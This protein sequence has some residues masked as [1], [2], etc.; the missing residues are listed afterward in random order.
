MSET[1]EPTA[2]EEAAAWAE[3]ESALE[4]EATAWVDAAVQ[5]RTSTPE[6]TDVLKAEPTGVT[7]FTV[8]VRAAVAKAFDESKHPRVKDGPGGKPDGQFA[9][10]GGG[11]EGFL[12]EFEALT[13]E[14]PM[15]YRVR[16]TNFR[17]SSDKRD[18][19]ARVKLYRDGD[20]SIHIEELLAVTRGGGRKAM[21][22]LTEMAD[23]H[24]VILDLYASP[25][26]G[27]RGQHKQR[28][29]KQLM[30]WYREFGFEGFLEP[31]EHRIRSKDSPDMTRTPKGKKQFRKLWDVLKDWVT[32]ERAP[33]GSPIGG[34]WVARMDAPHA[35]P[36]RRR[37][38]ATMRESDRDLVTA[39]PAHAVDGHSKDARFPREPQVVRDFEATW[40]RA[41]AEGGL[42]VAADGTLHSMQGD[43]HHV[44]VP[45]AT[46]NAARN[47]IFTHN[48]PGRTSLPGAFDSPNHRSTSAFSVG[49]MYC[50]LM[51]GTREF[52]AVT[53]H[54]DGLEITRAGRPADI[55]AAVLAAKRKVSA[56][57]QL[58]ESA[59]PAEWPLERDFDGVL[60]S[61]V[62]YAATDLHVRYA[63]ALRNRTGSLHTA[64]AAWAKEYGIPL[65][66]EYHPAPKAPARGRTDRF[67][68]PSNN[69]THRLHQ[70]VRRVVR[71]DGEWEPP[72]WEKVD[73]EWVF[74]LDDRP[75]EVSRNLWD[76]LKDWNPTQPRAP[77]GANNAGQWIT[78]GF[79][80]KYARSAWVQHRRQSAANGGDPL[81][82]HEAKAE[83]A[84]LSAATAVLR[85]RLHLVVTQKREVS[86][87]EENAR[88][89]Y[90]LSGYEYIN[91][92]LRGRTYGRMWDHAI[93][94]EQTQLLTGYV[95]AYRTSAPLRVYRGSK[96]ATD[97]KPG[98]YIRDKA[99]VSTSLSREKARRFGW[100]P[101]DGLFGTLFRI[102]L[103][104]GAVAAPGHRG[105]GEIIVQRNA[106]FRV[107]AV[108]KLKQG[109]VV[110]L[111]YVKIGKAKG[112]RRF[113]KELG[114]D[115]N[116]TPTVSR[117]EWQIGDY[118][119]EAPVEKA[120][121]RWGEETPWAPSGP[122]PGRFKSSDDIIGGGQVGEQGGSNAGG[123]FIG[124][125]GVR[126][127]VKFY[128]NPVQGAAEHLSNAIYRDLGLEA[129]SSELFQHD[130]KL[131]FATE[132]IPNAKRLNQV[133][134]TRARANA[135]LDGFAA[136]I[137][138][139]NW[140]A[141]GMGHDNVVY[142]DGKGRP[143]RA[144]NGGTFQ[145][146]A[147][148]A[149]KTTVIPHE[150]LHDIKEFSSL[151]QRNHYYRAVWDAA[152]VTPDTFGDRMT[153]QVQRIVALRRS[154]RGGWLEYVQH[155]IPGTP[156]PDQELM[157]EMLESR[158]RRLAKRAG[159]PYLTE[160]EATPQRWGSEID[161]A[162]DGPAPG[163]FRGR[164]FSLAP[165][166]AALH[167]AN[168]PG[169]T[170]IERAMWRIE[171]EPLAAMEA[172]RGERFLKYTGRLSVNASQAL[173]AYIG[174]SFEELNDFL[175][176]F[177]EPLSL[178]RTKLE[179]RT[180][181][182]DEATKAWELTETVRVYRM[183]KSI[184]AH[185][186]GEYIHD[187]AFVST[188]M[189]RRAAT[190]F[191]QRW[192]EEA[193]T[194]YRI[195]L[196]PGTT[197]AKGNEFESELIL[198]RNALFRVIRSRDI[199]YHGLPKLSLKGVQPHR[200]KARLV[201][202][203]Y[204]GSGRHP[205]SK[206][207]MGVIGHPVQDPNRF[208]WRD[209]DLTTWREP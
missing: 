127:Y 56:G 118:E 92:L 181:G 54:P 200:Q 184:V 91:N 32:Q 60:F 85:E 150:D 15:N 158:T 53:L 77:K 96:S 18:Y 47:G 19:T 113:V 23:K 20:E 86:I 21:E 196:P 82:D 79:N 98:Q 37:G 58:L 22:F 183:R 8:R 17:R 159:V 173:D 78:T 63:D 48:H 38:T 189:S 137:L 195:H 71:K 198:P 124:R 3:F 165:A 115:L 89:Y 61:A 28:T 148:G 192:E 50:H 156:K 4:E 167:A 177:E 157:A 26:P 43:A 67:A 122:G 49:D 104:K 119:I 94:A 112:S 36:A 55:K 64:L 171:H 16:I 199:T 14:N 24:G 107:R 128:A 201:D 80:R 117:F 193:G 1:R 120:Q 147:M 66:V 129:V 110:D 46:W 135:I 206:D 81:H 25:L 166:M 87:P 175:R 125:D 114:T 2:A 68:H 73:G 130:G 180:R 145:F 202:L 146:R 162:P 182:L 160:K 105:E 95:N 75:M 102:N 34:Q 168:P 185:E 97:L 52:R 7:L 5:W 209:A 136:D 179:Q 161:W 11:I 186:K 163:R 101:G 142:R 187:R 30:E 62:K 70:E 126:R 170:E 174:T 74:P 164:G 13:F 109:Y 153:K 169:K 9:S 155:H 33:K 151:F 138:T 83:N 191:G 57:A 203:R 116:A 44:A 51:M 106:R 10:T 197:I 100:D 172:W 143:I 69:A 176:G 207:S 204:V 12:A 88:H 93:Q 149:L 35:S 205:V 132:W 108:R 41:A 190:K 121:E 131:A 65:V 29:Q 154:L 72:Q 208:E 59:R 140:D 139:N 76:V 99:F 133:E 90:C 144:D 123:S 31:G 188:S 194:L 84:E 111:D 178:D 152:G 42:L 39:R 40:Y 103:P 45:S 134:L 141:V 6:E 27:V